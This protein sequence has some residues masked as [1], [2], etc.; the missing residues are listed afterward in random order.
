M[1]EQIINFI[2]SPYGFFTALI[3][4]IIAALICAGEILRG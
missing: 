4:M 2:N 3:V 1:V